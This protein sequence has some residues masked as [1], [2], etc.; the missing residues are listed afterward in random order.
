MFPPE[1]QE[2]ARLRLSEALHAVVS[3]RLLPRADGQGRAA[4]LE[5]L[6]ATGTARD[7]IRERDRTPALH[8]YIKESR[9]QYGMQT[10]DQHLMDLVA[11]DV[12]TYET[13]LAAASNPAD[14]QLQVRTLRRR[15]RVA[16]PTQAAPAATAAPA[17]PAAAEP[18]K[19]DG[20]TDDL[21]SM[22]PP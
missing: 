6:L 7:M 1:E 22:L 4:A 3:Q 16:T 9:E 18:D 12:V 20:F 19:P 8:D 15:S 14:F 21:S 2:I 10:F 11:E 5:V 13:A 17:A